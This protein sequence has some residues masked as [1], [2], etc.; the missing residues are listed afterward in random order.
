MIQKIFSTR[1]LYIAL[2]A[3]VILASG[4]LVATSDVQ[5]KDVIKLKFAFPF[6]QHDDMWV[7][8]EFMVAQLEE[9]TQGRVKITPYFSSSLGKLPDSLDMVKTGIADITLFPPAMFPQVFRITEV[10]GIP[11]WGIPNREASQQAVA[12]MVE[13]GILDKDF[14]DFKL[15]LW[16]GTEPMAF[17]LK[18]KIT[19]LEEIRKLKMRTPPGITGKALEALGCSTVSVPTTGIY[20]A[21]DRGVADGL[22]TGPGSYFS[23]KLSEVAPYC[24]DL[25]FGT[26][27]CVT[28]M[29]LK[30]WNSLPD[31]IKATWTKINAE[32]MNHFLS[33]MK[34]RYPDKAQ[35]YKNAK[36]TL[37]S[38]SPSEEARWL[39]QTDALAQQWIDA[40]EAKG[41]PAKQ[42]VASIQETLK[43]IGAK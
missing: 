1:S 40:T 27:A 9:R 34:R 2:A 3:I 43:R 20:M 14:K 11:T 38:L 10:L 17:G 16:E 13:K 29:N 7:G 31:D 42:A 12:D 32:A 24:L 26:G 4:T 8:P 5:A 18:K 30:K 21:I 6:P 36:S 28:V 22:V 15:L 35:R 37:Y 25:P 33:E 19:S 39:K 23:A 41:Y